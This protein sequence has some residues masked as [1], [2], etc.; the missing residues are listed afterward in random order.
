MCAYHSPAVP[1]RGVHARL[2]HVCAQVACKVLPQLC[3]QETK[4]GTLAR[5]SVG[6]RV[7]ERG[8]APIRDIIKQCKQTTWSSTAGPGQSPK[9]RRE[10]S[11]IDSSQRRELHFL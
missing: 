9:H 10:Q 8:T 7:D 2:W 4:L 6:G 1:L 5:W 11:T 3:L